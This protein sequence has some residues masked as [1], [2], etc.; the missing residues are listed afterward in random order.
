MRYGSRHGICEFP[1][2]ALVF[3]AADTVKSSA[4]RVEAKRAISEIRF[5]VPVWANNPS[6]TISLRRR[7]GVVVWTGTA[8]FKGPEVLYFTELLDVRIVADEIIVGTLSVAPG[9]TGGT[10]VVRALGR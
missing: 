10:V 9:G 4:L 1:V 8:R 2:Q 7:D 6:F 3:G 5:C